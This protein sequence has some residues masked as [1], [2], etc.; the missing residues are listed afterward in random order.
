[1]ST[2]VISQMSNT[3]R[4]TLKEKP[5]G[6]VLQKEFRKDSDM[7]WVVAKGIEVRDEMIPELV[8]QLN[9]R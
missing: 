2:R 3:Q 1:M 7:E 5:Y 6:V 9:R 8:K 4:I